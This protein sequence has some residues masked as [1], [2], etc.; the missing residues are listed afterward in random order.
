[1]FAPFTP[2]IT[3]EIYQEYFRGNE[4]D[5]SIHISKWPTG[6]E[7]KQNKDDEEKFNHLL[8]IIS[9]IRQEKT[10]ANKPMNSEIK[11]TM[12][13]KEMKILKNMVNDLKGV[14]NSNEIKEGKFSVDFI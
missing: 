9:K 13:S 3:E 10:K 1:M 2:F 8:E 14:T 4:K 12:E 5:K 7:I 6:F 11:L